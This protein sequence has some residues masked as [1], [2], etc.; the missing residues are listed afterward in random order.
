MFLDLGFDCVL[1]HGIEFYIYK[2]PLEG[3]KN[4]KWKIL[5]K[6]FFIHRLWG[7]TL[8]Y[9]WVRHSMF[10]RCRSYRNRLVWIP[11]S[12]FLMYTCNW[13]SSR[14]KHSSWRC[15]STLR[16]SR[17][18]FTWIFNRYISHTHVYTRTPEP[19]KKHVHHKCLQALKSLFAVTY[20][21]CEWT[22]FLLDEVLIYN[23]M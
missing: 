17:P 20:I 13:L 5:T 10:V 9:H 18:G 14:V 6:T 16:P 21:C 4:L 19:L 15:S 7:Q 22:S 23:Q 11:R 3:E 8:L 2:V 12:S 1:K